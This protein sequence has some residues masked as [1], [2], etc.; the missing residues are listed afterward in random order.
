ML[1]LSKAIYLLMSPHLSFISHSIYLIF[2]ILGPN[3][4]NTLIVGILYKLRIVI[5][6]VSKLW[7][8]TL[9]VY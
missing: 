1:G 2:N 3:Q 9:K 4:F 8:V 5:K 6:L 7:G